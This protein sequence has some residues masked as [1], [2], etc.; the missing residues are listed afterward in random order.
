LLTSGYNA[1]GSSE[2]HFQRPAELFFSLIPGL[3]EGMIDA[4]TPLT[5]QGWSSS[6]T[7]QRCLQMLCP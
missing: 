6:Q 2:N 4:R 3:F 1:P 7:S 5:A